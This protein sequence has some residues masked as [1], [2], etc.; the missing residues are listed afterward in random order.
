MAMTPGG[1]EWNKLPRLCK[2][3]VFPPSH[4]QESGQLCSFLPHSTVAWASWKR[5]GR[6]TGQTQV[7]SCDSACTLGWAAPYPLAS[8]TKEPQAPPESICSQPMPH[9][10]PHWSTPQS[11]S[12]CHS[13][14]VPRVRVRNRPAVS[15]AWPTDCPA[16]NPELQVLLSIPGLDMSQA[17]V[18]R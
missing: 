17:Q 18:P 13:H 3:A 16:S 10:L 8:A 6:L 15:S 12:Q 11:C 5:S 9:T 7:I 4:G 1:Q 14:L 2:A